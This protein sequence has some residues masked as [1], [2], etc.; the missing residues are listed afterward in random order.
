MMTR[1]KKTCKILKDI[2]R[3]IARQNDIEYITSECGFKG[4]CKGTCPKC[5]SE[6]RYLENELDKRR[7]LGKAVTIAG[8]SLG[9]AG[10]MAACNAP[11]Q[12][13]NNDS[14]PSL[15]S[16][17]KKT[18][19]ADED[20][21]IIGDV[22]VD[23]D[24]LI[25]LE[26]FVAPE[27]VDVPREIEAV[28]V[29]EEGEMI[30]PPM[31]L[32]G[33]IVSIDEL[34]GEV[35]PPEVYYYVSQMPG[36]PGGTERM[37]AFLLANIKYP[38]IDVETAPEGIVMVEFTVNEDG[39]LSDFKVRSSVSPALDAEALRVAQLMPDW[40]PGRQKGEAVKVR[41]IIPIKFQLEE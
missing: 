36:Y 19:A 15:F 17:I 41:Y 14:N 31:E 18:F 24:T 28:K 2:R 8:I 4:E 33:D 35:A 32:E 21:Q 26:G 13:S 30:E 6:L 11:K 39:K 10:A 3:E 29:V 20:V 9:M 12:D 7:R 27:I 34:S 38:A 40:E 1:G 37:K 25:T 5:E 22:P 23:A 16:V